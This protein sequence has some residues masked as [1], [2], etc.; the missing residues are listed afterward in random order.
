L[1]TIQDSLAGRAESVEL[2]GFSQ[3]ELVGRQEQFVARL[4]EGDRLL[5]HSSELRRAD[6]LAIASAG[7]YPEVLAR[8]AGRRRSAWLDNYVL[9]IVERD[10]PEVSGLHRLAELPR[11]LA[12]LAARNASELNIAGLAGDVGIPTT[13]LGPYLDLLETLYLV[14]RIPAWSTNLSKR[15]V[16]RPK[17]TL[18]DSGLAARLVNLSP[19]GADIDA[20]PELAGNLLEA[21]VASEIRRQLTWANVDAR[22]FHYRDRAG[23]EVDLVLEASDGRVAGIEVKASSTVTARDTRWLASLRDRVGDKFAGGVVLHTGPL[24]TPFGPRITAA[25]I[26]TIWAQ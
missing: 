4:L 11:L 3:G 7:G 12:L 9:R 10:A 15:V 23:A 24:S 16:S 1:P 18:V 8:S 5:E 19:T 14:H 21:F 20:R 25:P 17:I 13:T 2:F 6:Y 26:D 22:L